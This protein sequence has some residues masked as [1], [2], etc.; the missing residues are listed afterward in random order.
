M[1]LGGGGLGGASKG[2]WGHT[3]DLISQTHGQILAALLTDL[4]QAP[5]SL[6][7]AVN[8]SH[9]SLPMWHRHCCQSS[10]NPPKYT[11][12]PEKL[13]VHPLD[14]TLGPGRIPFCS[15]CLP[16]TWSI[17]PGHGEPFLTMDV[18][19]SCPSEHKRFPPTLLEETTKTKQEPALFR[20]ECFHPVPTS[21]SS[22]A[23]NTG[24]EA[25]WGFPEVP[26]Q[27]A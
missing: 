22:L 1:K 12:G 3:Q 24:N 20:G 10:A 15:P 25:F 2:L 11:F 6:W 14:P 26:M 8:S 18:V 4:R 7:G 21:W 27:L 17:H 9:P 23:R 16:I 13:N 19:P 5:R